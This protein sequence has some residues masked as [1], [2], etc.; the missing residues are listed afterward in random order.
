MVTWELRYRAPRSVDDVQ[1]ETFTEEEAEAKALADAYLATLASPSIR[2]VRLRKLVVARS[3]DYPDILLKY[4]GAGD[5]STAA[6]A[7]REAQRRRVGA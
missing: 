3:V 1:I 7:G 6:V 2:F 4:G 5:N